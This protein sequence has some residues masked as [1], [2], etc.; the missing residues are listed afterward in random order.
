MF[1]LF[2]TIQLGLGNISIYS[3]S[4]LK[5]K[6]PSGIS[7]S[8]GNFGNPPYDTS[9]VGLLWYPESDSLGCQ[10]FLSPSPFGENENF[11]VLIDRGECAFVLKVRHAQDRG[12]RA[13]IIINNELGEVSNIIMRDNGLGGNLYIPAFLIKKFD[14]EEIKKVLE[15][16]DVS[17]VLNFEMTSA[18]EMIY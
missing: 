11:F 2:L 8:L 6:F 14:G 7:A 18:S 13:V 10:P 15:K 16:T 5:E 4:S 1:F 12:A 3:P 9:V 17:L